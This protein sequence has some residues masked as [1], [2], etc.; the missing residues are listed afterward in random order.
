MDWLANG[1]SATYLIVFPLCVWKQDW[2]TLAAVVGTVGGVVALKRAT[3]SYAWGQR[4]VGAYGC[5]PFCDGGNS[6]GAPGFPSGHVAAVAAFVAAGGIG[7]DVGI[8][9]IA[10]MAWARVA[11]RCH[12]LLQ[13]VAGGLFGLLAGGAALTMSLSAPAG[14]GSSA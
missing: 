3:G 11:K 12:S 6:S 1:I 13:V 9:W 14:A 7:L 10:A 4:P 2:A 5:G 8:P